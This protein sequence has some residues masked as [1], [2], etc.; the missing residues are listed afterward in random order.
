MNHN[1][2]PT[3]EVHSH[4]AMDRRLLW[5]AL[6]NTAITAAEV[7]G[8]VLSGSLAL[9]ADAVHNLSDVVALLMA[10]VAR[11][12]AR[13][14]PSS[15][16]TY[17]LK[18]V[19]V[20]SA[21]LNALVLL[22]ITAFIAREA[23]VRLMKPEPVRSG[24]MLAV[25]L[26]ALV[27]NLFSVMLLR[28]H[29]REDLN[30]KSAFL[31]LLQDALASLAVVLAAL[32]ADTPVGPYLDPVA[33]LVVGFAVLRSALSIVMESVGMLVEAVPRGLDLQELVASTDTA[34]GPARMH[35]VHVWEVG[36]G[37][38]VLTAHVSVPDMSLEACEGLLRRVREFLHDRWSI[39]H[40]TLEPELNGCTG[41][42]DCGAPVGESRPPD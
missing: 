11:R 20:L 3:G 18:R 32:F 2:H 37:Q 23:L 28:G 4:D 27:A 7:A 40:A 22:A 5:S 31:H 8:G 16:H 13:R 15:S 12:L 25:A 42:G 39:E 9:L 29:G 19:E 30:V 14:P 1:H 24:L 10:L 33:S 41:A 34:F 21:L 17:G 26:V 38:R 35:H 36:P 6:L